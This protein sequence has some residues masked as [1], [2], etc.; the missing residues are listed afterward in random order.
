[1]AASLRDRAGRRRPR[2]GADLSH[3]GRRSFIVANRNCMQHEAQK[4][5]PR[6]AE[7]AAE[8][9]PSRAEKPDSCNSRFGPD[10]SRCPS[11]QWLLQERQIHDRLLLEFAGRPKERGPKGQRARASEGCRRGPNGQTAAGAALLLGGCERNAHRGKQKL[12]AK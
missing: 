6:S 2:H 7:R 8:G 3:C 4:Q 5:I 9:Q 12:H 1:V 11:R 10:Y